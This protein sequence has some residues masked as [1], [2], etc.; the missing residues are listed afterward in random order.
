MT[1]RNYDDYCRVTALLKK[2]RKDDLGVLQHAIRS[3]LKDEKNLY[4]R[5]AL[6]RLDAELEASIKTCLTD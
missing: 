3:T 4:F 5:N 1:S 2:M 6:E